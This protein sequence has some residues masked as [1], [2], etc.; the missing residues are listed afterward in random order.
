MFLSK[1]SLFIP[2]GDKA[3]SKSIV[4]A[5]AVATELHHYGIEIDKAIVDRISNHKPAKARQF[6]ETILKAFTVGEVNPPLFK[7]WED[8]TEFTFP[9]M[10]VQV[11]GY[12][13][14][15][16]GNDLANPEYLHALRSNAKFKGQKALGLATFEAA[17]DHFNVLVNSSVGQNREQ[18][19]TLQAFAEV[20]AASGYIRSDESRI[21][22]LLAK[23][24]AFWPEMQLKPADALRYF[25]AKHEFTQ[26]NLPH[27]VKYSNMKWSERV[28]V[29]RMWAEQNPDDLMEVMGQNRAA[30]TRFF[31]HAKIFKQADFIR[32]FPVVVSCAWVSSGNKQEAT[33]EALQSTIKRFVASGLVESTAEGALAYRTF[34]SRVQT[35]IDSGKYKKIRVVLDGH[36]S[37]LLRNLATVSNAIKPKRFDEFRDWARDAVTDANHN[38]LFSLLQINILSKYRIIDVKGSTTIQPA[39]YSPVIGLIQDDIRTELKKRFGLKG[40]IKVTDSLK[41][42]AV[43]FLSRNQELDRGSRFAF[44]GSPYL[45]FFMHWIQG[46]RRTDLD[47]SYMALKKG[48]GA[49]VVYFGNQANS[50]ITQSGDITSAPAP[51]GGTEYGRIDLSKVPDSI[52]YIV[53]VINVY[54]GNVFSENQEA[55][56]GFQFSSSNEFELQRK[57]TRYELTQ[58][59][60]ANMPFVID[61]RSREIVI[62]DFNQGQR[63]GSTAHSYEEQ[64]RQM[65]DAVSTRSTLTIGGFAELL[66][67]DGPVELSIATNP[68]DGQIA[69]SELSKLVA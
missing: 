37:Y 33:P 23:G 55:C 66:S 63:A 20:F 15:L 3:R 18:Q 47:H 65:V 4:V 32:R 34:A 2:N 30:W 56:A 8:R 10:V 12:M 69:P 58:P 50:Y 46:D 36:P 51:N 62:I 48:G 61:M 44:D 43:P 35:A 6:A 67:G 9:E 11:V 57:H 16:S 22:V 25:A 24:F 31:R 52:E 45:Y 54:E 19:K 41:D 60:H 64:I 38:V 39:N 49:D 42:K 27:D 59:A 40:E 29:L 1:Y 17:Q 68:K 21:A 26:V 53:P 14:Q 7:D 13:L 28:Q 5:N